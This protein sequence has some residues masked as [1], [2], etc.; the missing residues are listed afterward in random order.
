MP[1]SID[2]SEIH[3]APERQRQDFDPEAL[4]DLANSILAVG[5][6]HPI[7][8]RETGQLRFGRTAADDT[9]SPCETAD[10]A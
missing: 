5:L 2:I 1:H 10:R 9:V 3:I 6:L 7:V 8:L 4:T